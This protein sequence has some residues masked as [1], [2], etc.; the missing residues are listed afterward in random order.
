MMPQ[1]PPS[2]V[3]FL[4]VDDLSENLV[5][6]DALLHRPGL[7]IL[8]ARSGQEALELLLVHDIA[9]AIVDVQM[10]GMSGFELAELMRGAERTRRV[11]II[12][13]TAGVADRQRRFQGYEAGAVDFL[14]KP[15][16]ADVLRSKADVFFELYRQR[17]EVAT[18]RDELKAAT[19]RIQRLLLE[20]QQQGDALRLADQR[21]DEFLA[22]LAHELRNP[23]APIRNAIEILRMD[24]PPGDDLQQTIEIADRQVQHMTRLIDDLLDVARIVKGKV[25]LRLDRQNLVKI[26]CNT[27]EDFRSA[28][29][30]DGIALSVKSDVDQIPIVGDA[31]RIAQM[32][33]NLLHN[34]GKFTPSG[35]SVAVQVAKDPAANEGVV[36]VIDNGAG[37]S[38]SDA[39]KLFEPFGQAG[40][41]PANKKGGLGL[42]LALTKGFIELH[43]GSVSGE[44]R[45]I[46]QGATFTLR[47]PVAQ[48]P[49]S[50]PIA[51][52]ISSPERKQLSVLLIEDNVDSATSLQRLLA[53]RGHRVEVA[54]DGESGLAVA[55]ETRPDVV[56]SDIRLPGNVDGYGVARQLRSDS[57]LRDAY[58]IALSGFGSAD[59]R[60]RSQAAGFDPQLPQRGAEASIRR[61]Y[62]A[63]RTHPRIFLIGSPRVIGIGRPSES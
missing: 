10:P 56:I 39:T 16:E 53:A 49:A 18:Q 4:I 2:P 27:A 8:Q 3:S 50:E 58:L 40:G 59:D 17:Q 33:G 62:L 61:W 22:V 60:T 11:P 43:S 9:L 31:T 57:S 42:G 21:K 23:L 63:A 51:T 46:G 7:Q 37:F 48:S 28:L 35:G 41:M 26:A 12:F 19:E 6:L 25:D 47:F 34:A 14:G 38:P 55:K 32:I 15:I 52:A 54:L 29:A 5:A 13:V 30:K 24:V 1:P 44:S 20:S 45:G 36:S